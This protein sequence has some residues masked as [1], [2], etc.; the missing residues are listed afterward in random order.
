MQAVFIAVIA[1]AGTLLG[2][3]VNGLFQQWQAG[4]GEEHARAERLSEDCLA[5]YL[6]F[7]QS[8]AE[9]RGAQLERWIA[10]RDHTRD[11]DE[12][13]RARGEAHRT[14]GAAR[15]GLLRVQLATEDEELLG[16][17]REALSLTFSVEKA[18]DEHELNERTQHSRDT[19]DAFIAAA[20]RRLRQV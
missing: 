10:R 1:V 9:F 7:A 19:T 15:S 8:I 2:A 17:A 11:S 20:G 13:R 12:Y 5:A 4:R 6:G 18:D 3:V 16:L 14:G